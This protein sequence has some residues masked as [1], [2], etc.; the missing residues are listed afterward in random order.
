MSKNPWRVV[1]KV[2]LP[3]TGRAVEA[4]VESHGLR[5]VE[6]LMY[7]LKGNSRA[8]REWHTLN[9]SPIQYPNKVRAWRELREPC[10]GKL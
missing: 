6:D 10:E 8:Q 7:V 9:Y 4:T 3:D 5:R 2:P 1:G